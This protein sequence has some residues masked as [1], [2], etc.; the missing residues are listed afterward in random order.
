VKYAENIDGKES[1]ERK[2]AGAEVGDG[3]G[4]RR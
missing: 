1:N 3:S 4:K 2:E